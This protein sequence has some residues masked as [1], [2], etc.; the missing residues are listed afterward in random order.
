MISR[1]IDRAACLAC[2][3]ILLSGGSAAS[4]GGTEKTLSGHVPAVVKSLTPVGHLS[5]SNRLNLAIGLPLRNQDALNNFLQKV[6]DSA[7]P[8]YHHYLT[9]EQFTEM[10][11]PTKQDYQ[12]VL[13]FARTNGLTVTATHPNR[14]LVDV[15]GAVADIEKA[16]HLTM[17]VYQHPTEARTFYAPDV[18]PSLDLAVP[19]L[20]ISGLDD[21][22]LPRP[23]LHKMP[24]SPNA[25]PNAGSGPGGSYMGNDFRAAYT[26]S[27][28]LSGSG[29]TVGLLE[30][31]GY[32]ASDITAYETI[33]GLPSVPLQ[34]VPIDGGVPNPG[35]D[36]DEVALDIEMVISMAPGVSNI[37]VYEGPN[38]FTPWVDLLNRMAT[39]NLANQLSCSWGGG[40]P[41]PNGEQIF[42]Q[43][44]AQGQSFFSASGDTDAST[45]SIPFPGESANITQ[46]GATSLT[47]GADG[48]YGSETVWNRRNGTGSSGGISP[49]YTIPNWQQGIDMSVNQGST[50]NRDLPDVAM[51]GENVYVRYN[52]GGSG[53][54][55]GTSCA[56]PLWAGF[57]ALVNQQAAVNGAPPIGFINPAIY[58]IGKGANYN[59]AF[60]DTTI[61]DNTS[62]RSPTRFYAVSGYDLCTGWG[63]P[64]GANLI[65]SFT[66]TPTSTPT[67]TPTP[68]PNPAAQMLNPIPG[69][70][71]TSSS[72]I[73]SWSAGN[74]T[75]AYFLYVGNSAGASDI[76]SGNQFANLSGTV[77]DIPT[78]GRT[79][80]VRL[81][82]YIPIRGWQSNDYT[83][84]AFN[85]STPTPTPSPTPTPTPSPTPTPT[86]TPTPTISPPSVQTMAANSV[87]NT[88]TAINGM[89]SNDGGAPIDGHSFSYW[90][91]PNF[92]TGIDDSGITVSGNN[93][94]AQITGL[95]PNAT[96]HYRASAHNSST[97][98]LGEGPGW[99]F[100]TIVSFMPGPTQLGNISTRLSVGTGDNVMIGGFIIK[101]T[102]P[103]KVIVRAIG[104]SLA[105]AG[106]TGVLADPTLELH[107]G[108]GALIAT[109]DNWQTTQIGGIITADQVS[110]IQNS[111]LA[112]TQA[113]E[114]AI[115][116]T[117]Q[118]GSY[119]AIVRGT[120]NTTGIALVESYDLDRTVDS[121]LANISTRGLVQTGDNVM[122]GGLIVQGSDPA[123]VIIRAIGPSL[124][125]A[126]ISNPLVDPTLELHDGSGALIA[127]ND[128]WQ[129]TQIGGIIT[130]DQVNDIQNSGLA[131]TQA[132]ESAIIATLQPGN[133]T[134]IVRGTNNTTGIALIEAYQLGN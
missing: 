49:T 21:F 116:A 120:N 132:A 22:L 110:D 72:E 51:V 83:Y 100:G 16:F 50:T 13:D 78:D 46:V 122:I 10:F 129:T 134:A 91:N 93:F 102:Q 36:N 17:R 118:P 66:S 121:K 89:V 56:A 18:D 128:N 1:N 60:H 87:G 111:G 40:P 107:D 82:S 126:G 6:Y 58:A 69:S 85:V 95:N 119:T 47:T 76:Y 12:A 92:P 105:G 104:P 35:S 106:L 2:M 65:A 123:R 73:F 7:S 71:F 61:G 112:P 99:G 103:K 23:L 33:A 131:P 113:A 11:G 24:A 53:N 96:Y 19:A 130:A 8:N 20:H 109:N 84:T 125:N 31:D 43:M 124:A 39:D 94:S 29:Q 114:S 77:S 27:V 34:N 108:N 25:N 97:V 42:Q 52:N 28:S 90:I 86:A 38:N 88:S 54:F 70:T 55:G 32:Y 64:N 117:L 115:I 48:S 68:T 133:Y 41:D 75:N 57:A 62:F 26:P 9:S 79:I 37:I 3:A 4:T 14:M 127:S 30:F 63:T 5:G 59:S 45:G 80:Y 101:G 98:D 44:A 15:N 74:G 81:S 67:P